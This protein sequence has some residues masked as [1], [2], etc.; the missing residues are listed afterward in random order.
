[1]TTLAFFFFFSFL[2][3]FCHLPYHHLT[4]FFIHDSFPI[5]FSLT[6]PPPVFLDKLHSIPISS[7]NNYWLQEDFYFFS[8]LEQIKEKGKS[9]LKDYC[10][11]LPLISLIIQPL[12][13]NSIAPHLS[14]R[15]LS[16]QYT[17]I[18]FSSS[19]LLIFFFQTL[20]S[21]FLS[22]PFS[23]FTSFHPSWVVQ[24]S[25]LSVLGFFFLFSLWWREETASD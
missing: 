25:G 10:L 14:F 5:S 15:S 16:H 20:F 17:T 8:I 2:V 13:A 6:F 3:F 24:Q 7:T 11:V 19:H 21:L 23:P 18:S 9:E 12:N 22:L 4:L 1:M